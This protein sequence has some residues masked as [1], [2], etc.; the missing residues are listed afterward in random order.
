[1]PND[2]PN[3]KPDAKADSTLSDIL[4]AKSNTN[5]C[6][7]LKKTSAILKF[8]ITMNSMLGDHVQLEKTNA[9]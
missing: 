4:G 6:A 1:M 9:L 2:W 5:T 8:L 3:L 7:K